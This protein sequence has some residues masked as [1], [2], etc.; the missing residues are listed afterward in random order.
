M[1]P[2]SAPINTSYLTISRCACLRIASHEAM[3]QSQ[4][5]IVVVF[6]CLLVRLSVCLLV[7]AVTSIKS[8]SRSV[9][10]AALTAIFPVES[11]TQTHRLADGRT[12]PGAPPARCYIVVTK[13]CHY[14]SEYTCYGLTRA[15]SVLPDNENENYRYE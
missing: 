5:V 13:Y 4:Q 2:T 11:H 7:S 14:H 10:L 8:P 9:S 1:P 12:R 6:V 15:C 3:K